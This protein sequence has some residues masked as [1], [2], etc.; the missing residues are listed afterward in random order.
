VDAGS[1]KDNASK[2]DWSPDHTRVFG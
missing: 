1:R 2:K